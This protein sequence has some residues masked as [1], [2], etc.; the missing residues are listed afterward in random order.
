MKHSWIIFQSL[1][2]ET[3]KREIKKA[4]GLFSGGQFKYLREWF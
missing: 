3:K 2:E 4:S 1:R